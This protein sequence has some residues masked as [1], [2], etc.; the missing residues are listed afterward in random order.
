MDPT[1]IRKKKKR[2]RKSG[3]QHS[4]IL[5]GKEHLNMIEL[6][7]KLLS[8]EKSFKITDSNHQPSTA[9]STTKPCPKVPHLHA[10]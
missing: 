8:F 5:K 6:A 7:F 9:N 4:E 2:K 3:F 1:E 10:F